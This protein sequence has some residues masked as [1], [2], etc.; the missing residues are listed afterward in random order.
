MTPTELRTPGRLA[1][2]AAGLALVLPSP[3]PGQEP[4]TRDEIERVKVV[5]GGVASVA[6]A[7]GD[8]LWP[9]FRPRAHPVAYTGLGGV[10]LHG[11]EG[12]PPEGYRPVE[13]LEGG[14]WSPRPAL[15]QLV[16]RGTTLTS[17]DTVYTVPDAVALA[18]HEHFHA[19]QR[20]ALRRGAGAGDRGGHGR[21]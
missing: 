10:V 7:L 3:A 5:H 14:A 18:I 19:H 20:G 12:E 1:V 13:G 16:S 17:L 9:G 2:A 21:S 15:G 4:S 11:W 8:D 6:E